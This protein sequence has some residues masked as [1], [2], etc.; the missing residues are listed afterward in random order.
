MRLGQVIREARIAAGLSQ[1]ALAQRAG[2]TQAAI[3]RYERGLASPSVETLERLVRGAGATVEAS[4]GGPPP[5][6]ALIR[7]RLALTPAQRLRQAGRSA[8]LIARGRLQL[9]HG[10]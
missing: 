1:R 6:V 9:R 8:R 10:R 2:S 7:S 3:S 4:L 5:D